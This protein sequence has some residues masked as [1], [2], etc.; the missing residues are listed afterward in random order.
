M[1]AANEAGVDCTFAIKN[2]DGET[3][4]PPST[5][6]F[7]VDKPSKMS[8]QKSPDYVPN[9]FTDVPRVNKGIVVRGKRTADKM[10]PFL[11]RMLYI[12][13]VHYVTLF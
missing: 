10:S 8:E 11:P 1:E 9:V 6:S 13:N 4:V 2:V 5:E 3:T 12:T 7:S